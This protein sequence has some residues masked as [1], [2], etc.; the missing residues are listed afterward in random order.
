MPPEPPVLIS[1]KE[2]LTRFAFPDAKHDPNPD[3]QALLRPP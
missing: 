1:L 2:A 3:K